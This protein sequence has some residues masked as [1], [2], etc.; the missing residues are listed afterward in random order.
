MKKKKKKWGEAA[1]A[2]LCVLAIVF[3]ALYTRQDDLRLWAI[4]NG[5]RLF[6]ASRH[7]FEAF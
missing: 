6:I 2:A 7:I 3:A 1:L 4:M 5:M